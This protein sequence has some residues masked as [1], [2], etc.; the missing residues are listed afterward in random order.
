M[1]TAQIHGPWKRNIVTKTKMFPFNQQYGVVNRKTHVLA[2]SSTEW[3]EIPDTVKFYL[4]HFHISYQWLTDVRGVVYARCSR[5]GAYPCIYKPAMWLLPFNAEFGV[6]TYSPRSV[7]TP[8]PH[9]GQLSRVQWS[10]QHCGICCQILKISNPPTKILCTLK[11]LTIADP[12]LKWL[13]LCRCN[14]HLD[15]KRERGTTIVL[16]ENVV[17]RPFTDIK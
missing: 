10:W 5:A 8:C 17:L 11:S 16:I 7:K 12:A 4:N 15:N 13:L 6:V 9:A 2:Q 14:Q 3:Q 1:S